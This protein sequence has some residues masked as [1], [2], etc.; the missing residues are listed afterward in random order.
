VSEQAVPLP[1]I[2]CSCHESFS[3]LSLAYPMDLSGSASDLFVLA[4]SA[5]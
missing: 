2:E 5:S 3:S 4:L 1:V